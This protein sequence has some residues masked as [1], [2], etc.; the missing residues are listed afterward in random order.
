M[1]SQEAVSNFSAALSMP[2]LYF[3]KSGGLISPASYNTLM[4]LSVI[5][6]SILLWRTVTKNAKV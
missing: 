2:G 4:L 6:L 3:A 1:F 5:V